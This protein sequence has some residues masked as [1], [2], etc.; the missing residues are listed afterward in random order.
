M[1]DR[2]AGGRG[3]GERLLRL[4]GLVF[5]WWGRHEAGSVHRQ[6]LRGYVAGLRPVVRSLLVEGAACGCAVDG[7]GVPQAAL[8]RGR[9]VDVRDGRGGAAAQQR[10]RAGAA[11]RG[12]LAEDQLRHRQRG[13]EPVRRSGC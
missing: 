3:V 5:A 8:G 7:E 2:A 10:G 1:I 9:A 4:S 6:T 12:D 11:A 13:G